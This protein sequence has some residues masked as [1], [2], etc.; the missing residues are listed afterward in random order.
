[1]E[2][3]FLATHVRLCNQISCQNDKQP[4]SGHMVSSRGNPL[5]QAYGD[6][7]DVSLVLTPINVALIKYKEL[8]V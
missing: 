8:C 1:M 7:V 4:N 2:S 3:F 6:Y 5:T